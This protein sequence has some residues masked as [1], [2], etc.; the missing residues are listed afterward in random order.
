MIKSI[1]YPKNGK[2]Y[3]FEKYEKP[4]KVN[5]RSK[6]VREADK[7][8]YKKALADYKK[9]GN[10]YK[11][12]TAAKLLGKRIEFVSDKINV[13]FGENASGKTTIIN[14][15]SALCNVSDGWSEMVTPSDFIH[16]IRDGIAST[17]TVNKFKE[18]LKKQQK[19]TC[20]IEWDGA[21]I[22]RHNIDSR[23][24]RLGGIDDLAGS[25]FDSVGEGLVWQM[26][27]NSMSSMQDSMY[28]LYKVFAQMKTKV[29]FTNIFAMQLKQSKLWNDVW[30]SCFQA[31]MDYYTSLP[32]SQ[33]DDLQNTYLF[34]E[35]DKHLSITNIIDLYTKALPSV[36]KAYGQQIITVSHSPIILSKAVEETG[37]YN[38]IS[39]DEEYT[40]ICKEQLKSIF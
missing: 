32:M 25:V 19:N 20:R 37:M 38:I 18:Y 3:L 29:K 39:L 28:L 22:Y 11:R 7:T 33:S 34:D 6:Y 36:F 31:Q 27:R 1:I 40:E 17:Y 9:Y 14:S 23:L 21:P 26:H 24:G 10:T 30:S 4:E 35:F 16:I 8:Y 5:L 2:G 12:P 15:L 13:L